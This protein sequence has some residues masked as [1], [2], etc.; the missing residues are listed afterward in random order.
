MNSTIQLSIEQ[1]TWGTLR[2]IAVGRDYQIII[3]PHHWALIRSLILGELDRDQLHFTD[4]Q[5]IEYLIYVLKEQGVE[6][7]VFESNTREIQINMNQIKA[8]FGLFENVADALRGFTKEDWWAYGGCEG[9]AQIAYGVPVH[10]TFITSGED[11]EGVA[12]VI[13]DADAIYITIHK[14]EAASVKPASPGDCVMSDDQIDAELWDGQRNIDNEE[15]GVR[16]AKL[17]NYP[18]TLERLADLGF[19][20][21]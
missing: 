4:E 12:T 9:K 2:K 11:N 17:I 3:H 19:E 6:K 20:H 18:L 1:Y 15:Q 16:I 13:V 7:L 8:I 5:G 21:Q 14:E 10:E